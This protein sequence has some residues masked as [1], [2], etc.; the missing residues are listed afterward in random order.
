MPF[1]PNFPA[2]NSVA[3]SAPMREQFQSL[4]ALIDAVPVITGAVVDGVT[5]LP[6][7]GA[8]VATVQLAP[9]GLHFAFELPQGMA[10]PQ[11]S[12]FAQAMVDS[13]TTLPP[14]S[15]ATVDVTFDGT[16]VHLAF[17][18][19]QGATGEP[20]ATGA[21]GIPGEVTLNDLNAGLQATLSQTSANSNGVGT[22]DL[23]FNNDPPTLADVEL[24]RAKINE[25]IV[26]LR[27]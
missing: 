16:M 6:P 13:V 1:D 18:I 26:A 11:G 21:Q 2:S 23:V 15:L 22:L 10:G 5:T 4:K 3:V 7:G 27:R 8:A 25:L 17:G 24:L 19:P 12:P 20:G 14:G 9:D